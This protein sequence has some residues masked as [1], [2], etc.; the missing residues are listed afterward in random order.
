[1]SQLHLFLN[2]LNDADKKSLG[3]LNLRG[4]EKELFDYSVDLLHK[5]FP[6]SDIAAEELEVTK[7]HL[8]KLNS[9]V[10]NKCY[11]QLFNGDSFSLLEFLKQKGLYVLMRSE[12]KTAEQHFVKT[13]NKAEKEAFYLRLF[14]LFIDVSY[15]F[16]DKKVVR[17]Y[18]DK[19]LKE[20][21][22]SS[23][24]DKLYVEN[25]MLFADCNRCA[26]LKNPA[27]AFGFTES[28][29]LEKE[30]KLDGSEHYLAQYYLFRT[31]ISYYSF[32][33]KDPKKIRPYL[34]KCIALKD[35]IQYFFPI[36]VGQFLNLMYADRLFAEQEIEEA[37]I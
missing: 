11:A 16:F 27:K 18:G 10:L 30:K 33:H 5:E 12:A 1:M 36:D 29:L 14:H 17:D 23:I 2:T 22:N 31:F 20:K 34:E 35:D 15:K 6:E 25:H 37:L 28:D 26:A 9:V 24:S 13:A 21:A 4:K 7:T 19:Y 8:Y 3:D 32:Y